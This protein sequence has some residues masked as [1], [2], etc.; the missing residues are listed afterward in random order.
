MNNQDKIIKEYKTCIEY[1]LSDNS[2][3]F[4][5]KGC[6]KEFESS[7]NAARH[8]HCCKDFKT[9]SQNYERF[10][11]DILNL[12]IGK[13]ISIRELADIMNI[14]RSFML[15]IINE[16]GLK[17]SKDEIKKL[18]IK[19]AKET[20]LKNFGCESPL[21]SKEIREKSRKTLMEKYGTDNP[22]KVDSIKKMVE[23]TNLKKYGFNRPLKNEDI[24]QKSINTCLKKYG[25]SYALQSDDVK[26]KGSETS[27]KKYGTKHPMQSDIVKNKVKETNKNKYGVT[28]VLKSHEIQDK[29]VKTN[30]K[31]YGVPYHCM[32]QKCID[33][34]GHIISNV[35][36]HFAEYI[37]DNFNIDSEFEFRINRSSYDLHILNS[38]ILIELNPTYTHNST[39]GP[40]FGNNQKSPL[41]FDYHLS[42]TKLAQSNNYHCIH[43]F[44]WDD[45][46]KVA[47]LINPIKT[48]IYAR[49]CKIVNDIPLDECKEFLNK[50]H[51]QNT[52]KG[53]SVRI[54]LY[55]EGKL[56]QL[57]T[58]GKPRYNKNYQWE[59]I[60]Y[61]THGDYSITGGSQ[62]LFK[63]FIK[64]YNPESI[65]SYCDNSKF[66]GNVYDTLG[67]NKINLTGPTAHWF[68]G[69]IHVTDSLLRQRGFDQLF[70]T[71][72]GKGVS[73]EELMIA[74]GFVKVYDCGQK[75]FSY[76][77]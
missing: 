38:D 3:V 15:T 34:N 58:F 55:Y 26:F 76:S 60:R 62:R 7:F 30:L 9:Y 4:V 37:K 14:E 23:T 12:Y 33:A 6:G 46:F 74:Y 16:L 73:N 61:C 1:E 47:S 25:V 40:I 66:N 21:G 17:K 65:I 72:Y 41:N 35:N 68:N 45:W 31:K 70:G 11:T 36:R 67:F 22:M 39:V 75:V 29:I 51:L 50:Y 44:D 52:C 57:M 59:L 42:K 64:N 48:R 8:A 27:L 49:N 43:I 77:N 18:Q 32:T 28:C 56:V 2:H 19:R 63:Y 10:K 20:N 5:C 71:N 54:G 53:Q 24:K 13:E 69:E